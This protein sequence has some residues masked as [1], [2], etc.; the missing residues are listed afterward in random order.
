MI[1]RHLN[2]CD[3]QGG[4]SSKSRPSPSKLGNRPRSFCRECRGYQI[5]DATLAE[6]ALLPAKCV[7]YGGAPLTRQIGLYNRT[8]RGFRRVLDDM[9][10]RKPPVRFLGPVMFR[11]KRSWCIFYHIRLEV[12]YRWCWVCESP[13]PIPARLDSASYD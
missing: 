11:R 4:S 1:E 10:C 6:N 3:F 12:L 5:A 13:V 8:E 9:S 2:F 7:P